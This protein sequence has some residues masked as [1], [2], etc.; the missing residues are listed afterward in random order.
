MNESREPFLREDGEIVFHDESQEQRYYRTVKYLCQHLTK[1]A[2]Y[3]LIGA[4][5]TE[6]YAAL[7][8]D[9]FHDRGKNPEPQDR[10]SRF[11]RT[12]H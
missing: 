10:H 11:K 3:R 8:L 5:P 9:Y 2:I 12:V 1:E 7:M 6:V 4:A